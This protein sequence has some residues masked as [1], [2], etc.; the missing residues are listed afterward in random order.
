MI[1][2]ENVFFPPKLSFFAKKIGN[3]LNLEKLENFLKKYLS[4]KK[5]SPF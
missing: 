2:L 5:L 1:T 3:F 4:E